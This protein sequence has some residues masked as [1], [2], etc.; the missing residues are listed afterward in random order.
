MYGS[1]HSLYPNPSPVGAYLYWI[2]LYFVHC[3]FFCSFI[4]S[5]ITLKYYFSWLVSFLALP[6]LSPPRQVPYS[7][8]PRA[9]WDQHM[10]IAERQRSSQ[11]KDLLTVKIVRNLHYLVGWWLCLRKHS[12]KGLYFLQDVVRSFRPRER[13]STYWP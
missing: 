1:R 5:Y 13:D 2:L 12:A 10:T 8:H 3:R 9:N 11:H 4:F 6:W 7:S